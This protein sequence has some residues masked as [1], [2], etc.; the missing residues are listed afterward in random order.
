VAHVARAPR[1]LGVDLLAGVGV[2]QH[3]RAG[4]AG[5]RGPAQ[6]VVG[7]LADDAGDVVDAERL[8][9]DGLAVAVG[10]TEVFFD[11]GDQAHA[12][13]LVMAVSS[14]WSRARAAR[15]ADGGRPAS[16]TAEVRPSRMWSSSNSRDARSPDATCSAAPRGSPTH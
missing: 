6:A 3:D 16:R 11:A 8:R 9:R 14:V 15:R 12:A 13:L 2:E 1:L 7:G 5:A 10:E 4:R